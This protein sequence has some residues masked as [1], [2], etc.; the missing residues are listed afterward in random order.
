MNSLETIKLEAF[1]LTLQ[2]IAT[3]EIERLHALSIGVG[4]PHR[5]TDW[6][7]LLD[8]GE[9]VVAVDEIGRLAGSAMWFN[10]DEKYA[11]TGMVI[12]AHRLQKRG[13]GRWLMDYAVTQ[14]GSRKLVLNA[15][16]EARRLCQPLGLT[17]QK[18]IYQ[19]QGEAF[20]LAPP[21]MPRGATL[22]E[23]GN[24]DLAGVA[25]LD[26]AAYGAD[27]SILISS[28]LKVS[29]G[30]VLIRAGRVE[31]FSLC[32]P[33]GR[34]VLI[35]PVIAFNDEDAIAVTYPHFRTH[36]GGFVRLD[37]GQQTGAFSQYLIHAGLPVFDFVTAM[38][39]G[40]NIVP[41]IN[42]RPRPATVYALACLAFG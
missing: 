38:V 14:I 11:T 13:A 7:M 20:A 5:P 29:S 24:F 18:T 3:V 15:T 26:F 19:C 42:D 21:D 8:I 10:Y 22:R 35:G 34:G 32:R 28:L 4:W 23:L 16:S 6:Q 37:T 17:A 12:T 39:T 25:D 1:E 30:V 31:A 41:T 40:D 36:K 9:G 33:F 27:R 2:D